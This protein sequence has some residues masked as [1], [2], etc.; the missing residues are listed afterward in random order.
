[1]ADILQSLV[2]LT[3]TVVVAVNVWTLRKLMRRI[4]ALDRAVVSIAEGVG[5]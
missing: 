5:E 3:L 2:T 1:M 4:E